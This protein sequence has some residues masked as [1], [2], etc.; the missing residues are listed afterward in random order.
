[1]KARLFLTPLDRPLSEIEIGEPTRIS[2]IFEDERVRQHFPGIEVREWF[3]DGGSVL[4]NGHLI[5]PE[6]WAAITVK[7]IHGGQLDFVRVPAGKKA[8]ALLAAVAVVA[9]TAGIGAYGLPFLGPA[10][11]AGSIGAQAVAAGIGIAGSLAIAALTAPPK[12]GNQGESRD[13][14]QAG[15][16]GNTLSLL[17]VL[18]VV[19]GKIG[20]SP[21][22][23][24]P[25]YTVW[26]GD[27]ITAY[28]VVG[29][30]G[31][32]LIENVRVNGLPIAD[33]AGAVYETREGAA[34]EA[35][36]TL[37]TETVIEERDGISLSNFQTD[38]ESS[39][40]DTLVDQ[41]TP[42]NSSPKQHVFQTAGTFTKAVIRLL[43]P[44]GI[45]KSDV[46]STAFVPI[47]IEFRKVGDADW[48]PGP[49]LHIADYRKGSGPMRVEISI[50]R[51]KQPG[52]RHFSAAFNEY[53]V[54]DAVART[55][56]GQSF[57]YDADPYFHG[58]AIISGTFF[59]LNTDQPLFTNYTTS[60]YTV[61]ASSEFSTSWRAWFAFNVRETTG[62][63]F[64]RPADNSLPAWLRIDL[65]SAKTF[66]SYMLNGDAGNFDHTPTVWMPQGSNDGTNWVDLDNQNVD[67]SDNVLGI[68]VYQIDNPGSYLYYRINFIANGGAANQKLQ[69][70][71]L[72]WHE[73]DAPGIT[74][75]GNDIAGNAGS[76][77]LASYGTSYQYCRSR[78]VSLDKKGARIFLDP[79]EWPEGEYEIRVKRGVA[80]LHNNYE[81]Y[82]STSTPY[83]YNTSAANAD[84]FD[85]RTTSGIH[86]IFIGQKNYR[87]D[88][89]VEAFQTIDSEAPFDGTG[90]AL[91]AVAIPNIQ[92]SSIFAEF[93]R[94]ASQWDGTVWLAEQ[95][96][97][98]LPA[99][100]YRDLL[101]GAANVVP[102][103]GEA[104]DE[105]GLA[106]WYERC[107][108]NGYE[109]NAI[110]QGARVDEAKQ[111]LASAGYA[112]PRDSE[113]YGVI[114]DYDTTAEP[115]RFLI[116]PANSK[117]EGTTLD[118][119]DL[120]DAIRAEFNNEALGYAVD[121]RII[122]APGKDASTAKIFQRISYP[123]FTNAAK[124]DARAT[125][126]LNQSRLRQ[127]RY[128]CRMGLEGMVI[129][130]DTPVVGFASDVVDGARA[131][132]FVSAI[133]VVAGDV[134][135]I[136]LDNVMPWGAASTFDQIEDI[137]SITDVLDASMPMGVAI[138]LPSGS[139]L[140]KQVNEIS[141]SNVCTF[142]TPFPLAGSGLEDVDLSK[143]GLKAVAGPWGRIV[144]RCKV[145]S[146]VPQGFEERLI[147]LAD[148]AP[149]LFS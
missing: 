120:P 12:I 112:S 6:R 60:G 52:G 62:G 10:F 105:D 64:W 73:E 69:V 67:I 13:L 68:G 125:F 77:S 95:V 48:R 4:L 42:A 110:L 111:L 7:P 17:D 138:R 5:P 66:R 19:F 72:S 135:S 149:G 24:A 54:I 39:K 9:L 23:L 121:H 46:G 81:S 101:L 55:G 84:Y 40:N 146:V 143:Q 93:T 31:R 53:P 76:G 119:V 75:T 51:R 49:T 137:E 21:P 90:I 61:S 131:G 124:V 1:M 139:I 63:N 3:A 108:A 98:S 88:C 145:L 18:P 94:Y 2:E 141:D 27:N 104:I 144:R 58:P 41:A 26:D 30:Q 29:V 130:R 117:D 43:F 32:C 44:S 109:A 147:V 38:L 113:S 129:R 107:E 79:D 100:H 134:V 78:Y 80:G 102:V 92:I 70:A 28:A 136:T 14:A 47:R 65:P 115:V 127:A 114:E 71:W 16:S 8:F 82:G 106:A 140:Q 33:Y 57:A 118:L 128:S 83:R 123:G 37:F 25:P 36:R 20:A 50:E 116:S 133:D 99:A 74:L 126:D 89:T 97:T 15:V 91:V 11:A 22:Y 85:Y 45:V 56:I 96:P 86:K 87:S 35:A 132:G 148:E 34:G 122:Y 142:T 103:P 59:Y